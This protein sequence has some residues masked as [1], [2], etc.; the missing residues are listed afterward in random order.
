MDAGSDAIHLS[1]YG[2]MT[3]ASA[4]TEGTLPHREAKHSA[5]S[6][7]LKKS[8]DVPVIGVG[9]IQ[10]STGEEMI[11]HGKADLIAMGRQML[12]DPETAKKLVEAPAKAPAKK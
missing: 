8:I 6:G 10:P 9:R 12:A 5:L 4:F 1:A 7:R 11:A 2:D 3:S